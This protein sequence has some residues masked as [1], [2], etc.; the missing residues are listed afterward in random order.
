MPVSYY[1]EDQNDGLHNF[2]LSRNRKP[3]TGQ[4]KGVSLV[5]GMQVCSRAT[6][7]ISELFAD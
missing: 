3:L 7:V 1:V 6:K 4:L 5:T 2:F